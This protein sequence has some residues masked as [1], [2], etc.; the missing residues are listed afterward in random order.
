[1]MK[2][3]NKKNRHVSLLVI[4]FAAIWSV[5]TVLPTQ[6]PAQD[7]D[8]VIDGLDKDFSLGGKQEVKQSNV[9]AA[10]EQN[11]EDF[12]IQRDINSQFLTIA[13][14]ALV[15]SH[16]LVNHISVLGQII[17]INSEEN[18]TGMGTD[19][20][21]FAFTV[22]LQAGLTFPIA[23]SVTCLTGN[24]NVSA[25][26]SGTVNGVSLSCT[27]VSTGPFMAGLPPSNTVVTPPGTCT[28]T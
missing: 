3:L 5:V 23:V 14:S 13:Y 2:R 6:L 19:T 16:I 24:C 27:T 22:P 26:L 28:T 17:P 9:A 15:P 1:M 18:V 7:I 4:L 11:R 10:N 8:D 20:A 21:N 12:Q 25:S